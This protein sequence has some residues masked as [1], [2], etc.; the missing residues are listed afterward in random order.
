MTISVKYMYSRQGSRKSCKA[1]YSMGF[2]IFGLLLVDFLLHLF[3]PKYRNVTKCLLMPLLAVFYCSQASVFNPLVVLA[4][5]AAWLGDFF[6][7]RKTRTLWFN[8]GLVSFLIG[9]VIYTTIFIQSTNGLRHLPFWT[10]LFIIP[11]LVHLVFLYIR[12]R[13]DLGGILVEFFLYSSTIMLMSLAAL[14]RV[15]YFTGWSVWLPFLGS[16]LFITSDSMLAFNR[17]HAKLRNGDLLI[18]STYFSAQTLIVLGLTFWEA[19]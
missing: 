7:T 15:M 6:L 14:A 9:H 17:F 2:F 3:Y 16:L 12:L 4:L 18:M 19:V 10:F 1:V 5:G 11:Y 8:L 13:H